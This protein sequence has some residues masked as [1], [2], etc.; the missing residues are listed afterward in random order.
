MELHQSP[1]E[2]ELRRLRAELAEAQGLA[3]EL[4]GAL[5]SRVVIEQAKGVVAERHHVGLQEAFEQL[6]RCARDGNRKLSDVCAGVA[7]STVP[8]GVV[9]LHTRA[10]LLAR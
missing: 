9:D 1:L 10:A 7:S 4:Q 5:E 3:R 6:R 2:R 8:G